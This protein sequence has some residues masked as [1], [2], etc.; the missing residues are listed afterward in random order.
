M[1]ER[2]INNITLND[3]HGQRDFF[4]NRVRLEL[5]GRR[6]QI[7]LRFPFAFNLELIRIVAPSERVSYADIV[8]HSY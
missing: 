5:D 1:K 2:C 3:Q 7:T 8:R 4:N 6:R